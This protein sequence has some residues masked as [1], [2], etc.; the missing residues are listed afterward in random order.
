MSVPH[1]PPLGRNEGPCNFVAGSNMPGYLSVADPEFF[2]FFDD[3]KRYLLN[4]MEQHADDCFESAIADEFDAI[5]QD[6]NLESGPFTTPCIDDVVYWVE[7]V[8]HD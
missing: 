2:E 4:L 7:K 8:T 3:A 1:R 5:A 6:C